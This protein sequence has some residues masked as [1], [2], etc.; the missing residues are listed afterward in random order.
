M[1]HCSQGS[2][3][4]QGAS[5]AHKHFGADELIQGLKIE[6]RTIRYQ[7]GLSP[8]NCHKSQLWQQMMATFSIFYCLCVSVFHENDFQPILGDNKKKSAFLATYNNLRK[9]FVPIFLLCA[10]ECDFRD[11]I[12][13]LLYHSVPSKNPR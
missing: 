12:F 3:C 10:E 2:K 6:N 1:Q 11:S 13:Y 5:L 7:K 8:E 4:A 9:D